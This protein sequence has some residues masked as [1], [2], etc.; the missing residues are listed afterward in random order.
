MLFKLVCESLTSPAKNSG[1]RFG[2]SYVGCI[3]IR[4]SEPSTDYTPKLFQELLIEYITGFGKI[5]LLLGKILLLLLITLLLFREA[6]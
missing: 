2:N 5:L 3:G 4:Y 6:E 1:S